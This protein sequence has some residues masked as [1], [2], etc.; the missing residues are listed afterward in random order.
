MA[1][2]QYEII[3]KKKKGIDMSSIFIAAENEE[4]AVELAPGIEPEHVQSVQQVDAEVPE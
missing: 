1:I 3:L 2:N 4:Q